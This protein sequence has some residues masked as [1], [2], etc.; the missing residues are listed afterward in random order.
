L[1]VLAQRAGMRIHEV[2]VDWVEDPDSRV[3][4]L[5]TAVDDL[6]GVARLALAVPVT[7]FIAIGVASTLAYALLFAAVPARELS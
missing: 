1:L 5:A 7:R 4:T 2:A 3:D 6:R